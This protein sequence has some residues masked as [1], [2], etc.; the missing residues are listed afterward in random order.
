MATAK[1]K[2]LGTRG[3]PEQTRADILQAAIIEFAREGV[4]GARID[5]IARAARVNKALLYYYFRDKEALYGAALD[6]VFAGLTERIEQVLSQDLPA[7]EKLLAFVG[8]HFDFIASHA[9]F[10]RM[11]QREVMRVG[12][13]GSPHLKRIVERYLR[14]TFGRVREVLLEGMER[15]EIRKLDPI[16]A[17][18]SL[19]ALNIFYFS[20]VPMMRVLLPGIDPLAPEQVARRRAAVLDF[21][22]AAMLTRPTR[23]G[24]LAL[25][26]EKEVR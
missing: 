2:P 24:A 1:A 5:A 11:V 9:A 21:V 7:R 3:Q 10:P 6:A 20:S 16:D 15:G 23:P 19:I 4:E 14:P 12:R 17:V 8:A 25:E 13:K 18:P 22:A 26:R